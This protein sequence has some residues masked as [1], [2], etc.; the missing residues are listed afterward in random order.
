MPS[1]FVRDLG[2]Y[3]DTDVSMR[4]HVATTVSSCF[5]VLRHLRSIRRSVSRLVM[6]SLVVALVLTRLD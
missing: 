3:I 4:T 5:A 6:Q 1:A 2:I